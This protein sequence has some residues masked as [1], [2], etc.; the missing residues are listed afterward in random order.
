MKT[1][2]KEIPFLSADHV[3]DPKE[4]QAVN[5]QGWRRLGA[6]DQGT[7]VYSTYFDLAGLAMDN[8]T[9]FFSGATVQDVSIPLSSAGGTA[10]DSF[11]IVDLMT[12]HPLSDIEASQ[13]LSVGNFAAGGGVLTFDQTTYGRVRHFNIDLDNAAALYYVTLGDHQTGSL[14]ST[15]SDRIYCY[16]VVQFLSTTNDC[17][18][19]VPSARYLLRAEAK[20]E[21]EY[22]YLMR[23]K[24][25]YELQ[26]EPDRD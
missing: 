22:E 5:N 25:S 21:A 13:Y 15:A 1:L 4:Y 12:T 6:P 20:E 14:D 24:R 19:S 16:R 18:I 11:A 10:G 23:L 2:A 9:L 17:L 3:A 8:K 7:F 26:Q